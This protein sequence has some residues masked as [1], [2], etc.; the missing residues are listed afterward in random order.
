MLDHYRSFL[1]TLW[2]STNVLG[3]W[4]EQIILGNPSPVSTS[5]QLLS[6]YH[7]SIES[8]CSCRTGTSSLPVSLLQAPFPA[9]L[10]LSLCYNSS[11]IQDFSKP[12]SGQGHFWAR[13]LT[14]NLPW[15]WEPKAWVLT[16]N[17]KKEKYKRRN[18]YKIYLD[19]TN[20]HIYP[21]TQIICTLTEVDDFH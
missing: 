11:D 18:T 10:L 5:G 7:L 20:F 15:G 3:S 8:R 4:K 1:V 13:F 2:K 17:R 12:K 21:R 6:P 9:I 19:L 14:I 16:W